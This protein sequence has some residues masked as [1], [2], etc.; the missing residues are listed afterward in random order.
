[1][2][3]DRLGSLECGFVRLVDRRATVAKNLIRL[4]VGPARSQLAAPRLAEVGELL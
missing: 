2:A 4:G 3:P 1:M